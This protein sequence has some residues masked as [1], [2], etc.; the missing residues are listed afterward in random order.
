MKL[1][2]RKALLALASLFIVPMIGSGCSGCEDV[3]LVK[4]C[5]QRSMA[6]TPTFCTG[7]KEE[8]EVVDWTNPEELAKHNQGACK[9]GVVKCRMLA[10]EINCPD[11][12]E[13]CK[14]EWEATAHDEVCLGYV[15]PAETES[16]GDNIDNNCNGLVD[17]G[18][19]K[20]GDGFQTSAELTDLGFP[21]GLD[22]DDN[23][24]DINPSALE[25]CNG[26]DDNCNC[27]NFQSNQDTNG[28]GVQCGCNPD[29]N[30]VSYDVDTEPNVPGTQHD[31]TVRCCD[32]NVDEK[33]NG[34]PITYNGVCWSEPP[35]GISLDDIVT[36]GTPCSYGMAKEI[37][38]NGERK[39]EPPPFVGPEP[40][41][42]D[43]I[44]NDCDGATDEPG[45][46]VGEGDPCGS[47]I[48]M[49]LPGYMICD[50][51]VKD[52][53]C[54]N[55]ETG[56]NPDVCDGQDNDCDLQVDEDATPE[57]CHN[58]CPVFGYEYCVGGEW[59]FCD[60]PGPVSEDVEP[61]NGLD[62]DCDG[63]VD[64]GQECECEPDEVGPNAPDCTVAEMQSAGLT[65]GAGKKDCICQD[66]ECNYGRLGEWLP[67]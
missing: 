65:C 61:C 6:E 43:G 56:T 37:C 39:C 19:D 48:G 41:L 38:D 60:A 4:T 51:V 15:P 47:D 8:F 66:G 2:V 50:P 44:D 21:C 16:C 52:M 14:H 30:C 9:I 63:Q 46:I 27:W 10:E 7:S 24:P 13:E 5:S 1:Q 25:V 54:V 23:N 49:C 67:A 36:D 55:A 57:L 29:P 62:D 11:G 58:G 53:I 33:P 34:H 64:E 40:E 3:R 28:D 35:P 20:D 45:E 22:C 32:K 12:D 31:W 26:V 18:Y 42:C 59:T 17:E